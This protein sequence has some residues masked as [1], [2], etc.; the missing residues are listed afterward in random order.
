MSD[1]VVRVVGQLVCSDL[2]LIGF[3]L[4]NLQPPANM[5]DVVCINVPGRGRVW[6]PT[7]PGALN[8]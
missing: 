8:R 6:W 1:I 4:S 7:I 5:T 2:K 3:L